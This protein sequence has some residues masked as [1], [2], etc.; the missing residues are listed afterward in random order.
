MIN[1]FRFGGVDLAVDIT[2]NTGGLVPNLFLRSLATS[3]VQ[4]RRLFLAIKKHVKRFGVVGASNSYPSSIGYIWLALVH[5]HHKYGLPTIEELIKLMPRDGKPLRS[6]K[7]T[8]GLEK[9]AE[10]D[11]SLCGKAYVSFAKWL[12]SFPFETLAVDA[13][14]LQLRKSLLLEKF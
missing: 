6:D 9:F 10:E 5:L 14:M 3:F 8:G 7:I 12:S 4:V 13:L 1:P 11:S 2:D